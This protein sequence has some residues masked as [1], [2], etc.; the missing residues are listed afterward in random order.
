MGLETEGRL[1]GQGKAELL[2]LGWGC[3][4]KACISGGA[5]PSPSRAAGGGRA[6]ENELSCRQS[7]PR[8]WGW[9]RQK[10]V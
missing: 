7:G 5:G 10:S 4:E 8:S 3:P 1:G 2:G 6:W 9:Q